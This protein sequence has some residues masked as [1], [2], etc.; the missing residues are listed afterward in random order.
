MSLNDLPATLEQLHLQLA[1]HPQLDEQS[2]Q[3]LRV[4]A[5]DIENVL[6]QADGQSDKTQNADMSLADRMRNL[7]S[8]FEV[9]HPQ[10]T[11]TLSTIAERLSD[12]G[13]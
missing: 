5:Q 8:D 12:M 4:L 3:S 10:L 9:Q 6:N 13:I 11:N 7:I 1:Q 2:I